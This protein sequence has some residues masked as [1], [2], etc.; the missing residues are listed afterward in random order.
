MLLMVCVQFSSAHVPNCTHF[1]NLIK[2][3]KSTLQPIPKYNFKQNVHKIFYKTYQF[4]YI[5][6][7]KTK[8]TKY[9]CKLQYFKKIVGKYCITFC[10]IPGKML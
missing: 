7:V 1:E 3:V 5:L 4:Q 10:A 2:N 9:N 6:R 8:Y